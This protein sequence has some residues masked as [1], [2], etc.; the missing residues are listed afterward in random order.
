ML[1]YLNF[2]TTCILHA[3]ANCDDLDVVLEQDSDGQ[4]SKHEANYGVTGL[5]E[6]ACVWTLRHFCAYL[7][8]HKCI[9]YTDHSP[10][11]LVLATPHSS[12]QCAHWCDTLTKFHL[13][14]HYQPGHIYKHQS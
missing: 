2:A 13:E 1:A 3:D 5:E 4:S 10:L 7:R 8:R 11:K 14:V 6:L 9:A 12:G